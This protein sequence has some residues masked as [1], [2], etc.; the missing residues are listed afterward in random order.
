MAIGQEQVTRGVTTQHAVINLKRL[1]K[2]LVTWSK[3]IFIK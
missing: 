3:I 2:F 1:N